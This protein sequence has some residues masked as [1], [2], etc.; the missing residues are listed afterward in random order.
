MYFL[1]LKCIDLVSSSEVLKPVFQFVFALIATHPSVVKVEKQS[2]MLWEAL[3]HTPCVCSSFDL[4]LKTQHDSW[5]CV[6]SWI[7]L[8]CYVADADWPP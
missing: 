6:Y 8:K 4:F 5:E 2:V 1:G 7:A 3:T